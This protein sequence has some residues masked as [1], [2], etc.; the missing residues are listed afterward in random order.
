MESYWEQVG[1]SLNL[2]Q[3]TFNPDEMF[4]QKIFPPKQTAQIKLENISSQACVL[5]QAPKTQ[6]I[7][8][9]SS[10]SWALVCQ[11]KRSS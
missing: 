2:S 9:S 11:V 1:P 3:E 10:L 7:Q 5:Q 8:S 6:E 4:L